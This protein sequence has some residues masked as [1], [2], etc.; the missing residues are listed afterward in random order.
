M[1]NIEQ[2]S[3]Y[4]N[5]NYTILHCEYLDAIEITFRTYTYP[6][7]W[8][9]YRFRLDS[10][11]LVATKNYVDLFAN[12]INIIENAMIHHYYQTHGNGD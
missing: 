10:Y 4:F 9:L 3:S 2:M 5:S 11:A 6:E 8:L 12:I 1:Y 7:G